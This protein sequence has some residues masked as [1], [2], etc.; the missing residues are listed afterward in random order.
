MNDAVTQ[1]TPKT[2]VIEETYTPC[3]KDEATVFFGFKP[4]KLVGK[5]VKNNTD[6]DLTLGDI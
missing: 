2:V 3:S 5:S 6:D 1:T 4:F